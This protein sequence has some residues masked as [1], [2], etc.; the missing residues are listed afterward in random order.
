MPRRTATPATPAPP[1][2]LPPPPRD[3]A[4]L[5]Q[6]DPEWAANLHT[7]RRHW[8]WANFSQFFYTFA[9]LLAMPDVFLSDVED[10]LA[11]G[12]NLYIPRIMHRLLYTLSQDRKLNIDNWQTALRRQYMRRDPTANPIGPEPKVPSRDSSLVPSEDDEEESKEHSS[13]AESKP[14]DD[15]MDTDGDQQSEAGVTAETA[16]EE[17]GQSS[18]KTKAEP[19]EE[20]ETI[21]KES[22]DE[23]VNPP[24]AEEEEESKDWLQLPML[25]KL[26]SLHLLTEWQFQ[27]PYRLRQLMKDDDDMANW[28]IEPIG[29]DAKTNAYWLIGPDRLWIQRAP[30]KAPRSR[31]LKRK[32]PAA[33]PK[34]RVKADESSF[35]EDEEDEPIIRSKRSRTQSQ[36]KATA[37]Q[38]RSQTHTSG[39]ATRTSRRN[40]RPSGLDIDVISAG[41]STRAAKVQANKK[42]DIQ[43]KELAEFQRQAAALARSSPRKTRAP[44]SPAKRI[45]GTRVSARL[46]HAGGAGD[47]DDSDDEWQQ[48]PDEWLQ[49]SAS[50]SRRTR[51]R[52]RSGKGKVWQE[53]ED[54]D[55]ER[56]SEPDAEQQQDEEE[57]A[58]DP[59]QEQ[60][61]DEERK[62]EAQQDD[63]DDRRE[64]GGE[65]G[66]E[67]A[68]GAGQDNGLLQKAGL[69]SGNVSD[70]TDLS[71]QEAEP[72][73]DEDDEE[74]EEEEAPKVPRRRGRKAAFGVRR[75]GRRGR[76]S[77][78]VNE[79][80]EQQLFI[81][82]A[83]KEA[84]P[85]PDEE[86]EMEPPAL[87]LPLDFVEWEAIAITLAEWEHVA[88]PFEK[89]TH[90][91]E[92]ALYKMLTKNI[93]PIVT[94]E[95]REAEKRR[96]LEEAIVHR[97]R[98][99]RIA[100]KESEKEEARLA[101]KR[102]AEEEEKLARSRRQ[103]A[104][105]K[106][107]EAERV[108][109]ERAR[110]ER[111]KERDAREA[112][113]K[114]KAERQEREEAAAA[115]ST[116]TPSVNGTGPSSSIQPSRVVTPNG[117]RTPDWVLDCEVCHK[118]G[119]N[120]DDGLPMVSCGSCNRWQH[121]ACHDL[122]DQRAG[123]HR[124]D[125]DKQQFFCIRCR[126]RAVNGGAYISHR[127]QPLPV[128][129]QP[130]ALQNDHGP[131]H[132]Q[133]PGGMD[134]FAHSDPRYGH[135]SP[136]ENGGGYPQ[137]YMAN[138]SPPVPYARAY[139][140][141]GLPFNHY[142][143]EQR[144]LSRPALPSPQ[145]SWSGSSSGYAA[146]PEQMSGRMP[147]S[148][149]VPQYQHNGG[150]YASNRIPSAYPSHSSSSALPSFN[151]SHD[152]AGSMSSSRWQPPAAN[153]YHPPNH[154]A[155]QEA[156]QSL[157]FMHDGISRYSS[158]SSGWPAQS[159]SY[160]QHS[161]TS[162]QPLHS[163]PHLQAPSP[164]NIDPLTGQPF[165]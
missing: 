140:S 122:M 119:L 107:E 50:P 78:T 139:T 60:A 16:K 120:M 6:Q 152:P 103:E 21:P 47:E 57:A 149:F 144:E 13:E 48:V 108:R 147:A 126:Q 70:L 99:S 74:E 121:I 83:V 97:K 100:M 20:D 53:E 9:P 98:S 116:A 160:G 131:I 68:D 54:E 84:E 89:A 28:R 135:R 5:E 76:K 154:N 118:Q 39:R 151:D 115:R 7:L 143:P 86:Q 104:R 157:A 110:E 161:P 125:W 145:G 55:Q 15:A 52:T 12:T 141:A 153:G 94:E 159:S 91:L 80:P 164:T 46:R 150:V 117:V 17:D 137:Q 59:V 124:R 24:K 72:P 43:A 61:D 23:P 136:V 44:A 132:L 29:Y 134:P 129:Q 73:A 165:R 155:V 41:K 19:R 71:E 56:E 162:S 51:T 146:R 123:R 127:S 93:V 75:S 112:R 101:A 14:K 67:N 111:A 148:H 35:D 163:Y 130:Y 92:K 109:R 36:S 79:Q 8:K 102:K 45:T 87:P 38:S 133:K 33:T 32:R 58:E 114:A 88:D 69:E 63:G 81:K 31:T 113:A 30:P 3:L 1:A 128:H 25:E 11:R 62:Y 40:G 85:E 37:S 66:G 22:D 2:P 65:E 64:E 42:L 138:N 90:Y 34:K 95:L 82:R 96:R 156:A 26:D 18:V 77:R 27:N 10:D 106:K 158:H 105:R 49:E 142:Q 4:A